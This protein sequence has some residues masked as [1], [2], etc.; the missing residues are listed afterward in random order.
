MRTKRVG[1]SAVQ[2]VE[3]PRDTRKKVAVTTFL[4]L[5]LLETSTASGIS[6]FR[7]RVRNDMR[8]LLYK[9]YLLVS[10]CIPSVNRLTV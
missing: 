9:M 3:E 8:T 7:L 6:Q 4:V 5:V 1:Y 10:T 2:S